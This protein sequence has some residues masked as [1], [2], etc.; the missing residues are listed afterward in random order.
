MRVKFRGEAHQVLAVS[1][2]TETKDHWFLIVHD[3]VFRSV[4]EDAVEP[5]GRAR[6]S[7]RGQ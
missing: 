1:F 2:D 4:R 5:V 3:G 6:R 7:A